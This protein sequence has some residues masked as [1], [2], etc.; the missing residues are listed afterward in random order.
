MSPLRS[1]QNATKWC[2]DDSCGTS[3]G[4]QE[5]CMSCKFDRCWCT[6]IMISSGT[7]VRSEPRRLAPRHGGPRPS[8]C[9]TG[10]ISTNDRAALALLRVPSRVPSRVLSGHFLGYLDE[11][12][13]TCTYH[14]W[15]S[16]ALT[17]SLRIAY[18]VRTCA[19]VGGK[20]RILS[21]HAAN[22]VTM[23]LICD[24][25]LPFRIVSWAFEVAAAY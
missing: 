14:R 20:V 24:R 19:G 13:Q 5:S 7:P 12:V 16:W 3:A 9:G 18:L 8:P 2:K 23:V 1:G 25:I 10:L 4:M 15:Y 22:L 11:M 17:R 21:M 6:S